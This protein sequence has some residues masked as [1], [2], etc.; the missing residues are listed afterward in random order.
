MSNKKKVT[1]AMSG[2]MDS[3]VAAYLLKKR[4]YEVIGITMRFDLVEGNR[5][6]HASFGIDAIKDARRIAQMI[7]IRHYVLNFT[8][9]LREKVINNFCQEY[10]KGRT[11]NPCVRCNQFLKFDILLNKARQMDA[12]FFA[13]GHYARIVYSRKL[14]RCLLKKAKDKSKDQSYFLYSIKKQNLPFILMP[15]GDSTKV[16]IRNLARRNGLLT[17]TKPASQEICFIDADYREF[18]KHRLARIKKLMNTDIKPG[19]IID[20]QGKT[21]GK[22]E[23]ICFY[24]LG[25]REGLGIALGY[26][27]YVVKIDVRRNTIVVG[28]EDELYSDG[29]IAK[30]INF[31]SIDSFERSILVKAKIR[32]NHKQTPCRIILLNRNRLKV[33]FLRPQ[34]AVT[35]GQSVVFYDRDILLG[36]GI[37]QKVL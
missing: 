16:R 30:E 15:L 33:K 10:L 24:T 28:K 5:K 20:T 23:G 26:R 1:V 17:A 12:Q 7:G 9:H 14:K 3:S 19:P 37:I 21:L 4:G 27:A 32:Y 8:K 34:R 11:P 22:H 36:G 13:T 2:G 29:L 18:L 6:K 25:Q 35:P 31:I